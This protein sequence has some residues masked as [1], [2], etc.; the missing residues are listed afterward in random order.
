MKNILVLNSGS[1]SIKYKLFNSIDFSVERAGVI[2]EVASF[3]QAFDKLFEIIDI[4]QI[5]YFGHRVVHGGEYFN[6]PTVITQDVISKIEELIPLAPLHNPSNLDGI[7]HIYN[8]KPEAKQVAVFDTAFH[9]SIAKERYLYPLPMQFYEE[10]HIRKYGFHGTSYSYILKEAAIYLNKK[11]HELTIIA[12]HLGNGA[13]ACAIKNGKSY[14]TSMGFSPLAGLMMGSRSGSIDPTII[15]YLEHHGLNN[16]EV[17]DILNHKSGF[18]GISGKSNLVEIL[19]EYHN[20]KEYAVLAIN[21][22]VDRV[23]KYIGGYKEILGGID[24]IVYTGG[25]GENGTL[26]RELITPNIDTVANQQTCN[27]ILDIS[28]NKT[29][30]KTLVIKTD[31][32]LE[33]AQQTYQ[34][35]KG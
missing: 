29:S 27:T 9:T 20:N 21:M 23:K 1:S 34:T 14:D 3:T 30:Y 25:I 5:E 11:P 2:K 13:S 19:K 4:S 18:L 8:F 7:N 22:F 16:D 35:L 17:F 26:I 33:I 32:E 10:N 12:L 24:A 28:S 15:H 31:E 6:T